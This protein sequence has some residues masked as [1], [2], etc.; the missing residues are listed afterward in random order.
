MNN[1]PKFN[2]SSMIESV[3][4][5]ADGTI[6]IVIGTQELTPE[7]MAALFTLK[8]AQGYFLFSENEIKEIDIPKEPSPEFKSD[9]TPSQRLRAALYVYWEK[10]TGKTKPFDE[11][12]KNW[13]EKKL[14]EIKETLPDDKE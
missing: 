7:H 1:M 12:Y 4:T 3:S 8:G 6:K 11:W 5:R 14:T 2:T 9:K 10:N 13:I